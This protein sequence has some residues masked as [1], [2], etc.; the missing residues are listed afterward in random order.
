MTSRLHEQFVALHH[1]ASPLLLTNAWDA[2]SARLW[3]EIGATAVATSSAAV[4]WSRGYADGGALPREALLDSLSDVVRV[5]SVPVTID[6]E[7]GY[8]E[9]PQAVAGL[10]ERVV[11]AGAVGIN[12]EDGEAPPEQLAAKIRAI[13]AQLAGKPLFVNARTDVYLR[14]LAKDEAAIAMTIARLRLYADAGAD[15]GFAPGLADVEAAAQICAGMPL[16]LN[17]MT[18]PNLPPI[19]ALHAA[20]VKRV[21][22]GPALF[23]VAFANGQDAARSFLG[24]DIAPLFAATLDYGMLNGLFAAPK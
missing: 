24:G 2:A 12:I 10:V 20:G 17:V 22:C 21:S 6:L 23:K 13:R 3:Q 4:A 14:G 18:T 8:S 1:G 19:A 5:T 16:A 7:D 9:D 15:G 11:A